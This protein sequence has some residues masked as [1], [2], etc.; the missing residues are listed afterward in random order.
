MFRTADRT[1]EDLEQIYEEL[2]H[3]KALSHLSTM[4]KR[5]LASVLM[6]EAHCS[7][8]KVCKNIYLV[9]AAGLSF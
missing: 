8:G 5:E 3:I 1:P 7:A 2:L 9:S 4:V 6:F